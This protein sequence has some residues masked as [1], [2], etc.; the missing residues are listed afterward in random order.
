MAFG[1]LFRSESLSTAEALFIVGIAVV[2]AAGLVFAV[3]FSRETE[4]AEQKMLENALA[5]RAATP[6][7]MP[8]PAPA[9]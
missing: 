5:T 4:A 2:V 1:F 3:R 6:A 7:A 8:M 9:D